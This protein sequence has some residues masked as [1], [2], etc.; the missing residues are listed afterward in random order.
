MVRVVRVLD[1][2]SKSPM[3]KITGWL[4]GSVTKEQLQYSFPKQCEQAWPAQNRNWFCNNQIFPLDPFR[5]IIS[6][7]FSG[8]HRYKKP[9]KQGCELVSLSTNIP[10][11]LTARIFGWVDFFH[12]LFQGKVI[13]F[14]S[15]KFSFIW[16]AFN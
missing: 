11:A 9:R 4:Q 8:F 16:I 10:A 7:S 14:G 5:T 15:I 13:G 3:S 6:T 2:Q 1:S 12:C